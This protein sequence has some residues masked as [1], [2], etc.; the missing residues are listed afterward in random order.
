MVV[1]GSEEKKRWKVKS[2]V[3]CI[4]RYNIYGWSAAFIHFWYNLEILFSSF[5]ALVESALRFFK[6]LNFFIVLLV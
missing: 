3:L 6:M 1:E 2:I 5:Y 4:Y